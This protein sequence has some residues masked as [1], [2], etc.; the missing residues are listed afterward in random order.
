MPPT[1]SFRSTESL[2]DAVAD[3][4][5][6]MDRRLT[7]RP[8]NWRERA[9]TDWYLNPTV[10]WPA[11]RYGKAVLRSRHHHSYLQMDDVMS[12]FFIE[13]GVGSKAIS[14][15]PKLQKRGM[16]MD[17]SWLWPAFMDAMATGTV[18]P[19]V[20]L[21]AREAGEPVLL[22]IVV[23]TVTDADYDEQVSR[24]W[25]RD[26]FVRFQIDGGALTMIDANV[27]SFLSAAAKATQLKQIPAAL[28]SSQ[29]DWVWVDLY[30]G[31]E[32]DLQPGTTP[33]PGAWSDADVWKRTLRPWLGWIR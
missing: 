15:F 21:V 12:C 8:W 30:I 22:D 27:G 32:L 4:A 13:K 7:H 19:I 26:G 24:S 11:F 20:D 28:H 25:A 17:K 16:M 9:I 23:S 18:T 33:V 10:D 29:L 5:A 14:A 31:V 2:A 1:T 3:T 6:I